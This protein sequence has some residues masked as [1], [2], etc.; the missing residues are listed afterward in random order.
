MKSKTNLL[1]GLMLTA[2]L[3]SQSLLADPIAPDVLIKNTANEV[4]EIVKKD[5]DIQAGDTQKIV[6]LTEEKIVP[7]FDF[8]RMSR[9]VLGRAWAQ[10]SKEQQD[11]FQTEFRNLLVR[12]YSSALA[13][14]RNQT[15][16]YKPL[17]AAPGDEEVVVKTQIV[18]PG[19]QPIP[20]DYSLEKVDN[21]WKV[22]DVK[23]D[24]ISLV[25]NY[26]G[27]FAPDLKQS[28]GLD[29]I[30]KKLVDKNQQ[31]LAKKQ[32]KV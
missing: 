16:D 29:L 8:V 11:K 15:I 18:Q 3:F 21:A 25:T 12:T 4:L 20:I 5:K 32:D 22:Y 7:H 30:I 24:S 19:G 9:M 17:R 23:I 28:G 27:Q 14:Y 13:K 31:L 6:A 10:A 1:A 26:K 2:A